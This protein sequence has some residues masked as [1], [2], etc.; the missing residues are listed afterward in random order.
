M[1]S[2]ARVGDKESEIFGVNVDS[3]YRNHVGTRLKEIG[4]V[5]HTLRMRGFFV[6]ARLELACCRQGRP[7]ELR[8]VVL[9]Q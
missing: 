4:R 3:L 5:S 7:I 8:R 2:A 6:G 1:E 9:F